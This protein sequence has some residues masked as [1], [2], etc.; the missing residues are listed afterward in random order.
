MAIFALVF[1]FYLYVKVSATFSNSSP[2]T[3]LRFPVIALFFSGL[4][5][6]SSLDCCGFLF[7]DAWDECLGFLIR[8]GFIYC[9]C[10][11]FLQTLN[12]GSLFYATLNALAYF[13][14]VCQAPTVQLY[15]MECVTPHQCFRVSKTLHLLQHLIIS[16]AICIC[17]GLNFLPERI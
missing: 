6:C 16:T 1:T 8:P 13:Y 14:M 17:D 3:V 4:F 2:I 7:W 5:C 9:T 10:V 15:L 11:G 12:T